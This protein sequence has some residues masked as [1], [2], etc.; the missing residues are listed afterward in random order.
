MSHRVS[1]SALVAFLV[2]VGAGYLSAFLPGGSPGWGPWAL[3]LGTVGALLAVSLLGAGDGPAARRLIVPLGVVFVL[4]TGGVGAGLLLPDA[5]AGDPL[6]GG[7]P[8]PAALLLYGAGLLPL[9]V[10][11]LAYAWTFSGT[12]LAEG[13]LE[14]LAA[15]ARAAAGDQA[16]TAENGTADHGGDGR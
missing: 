16:A 6:Y 12:G 3:L 2:L 14:R 10:V 13:E 9:L 15:R 11:P 7:L 5:G 4:L 1:L 8:L